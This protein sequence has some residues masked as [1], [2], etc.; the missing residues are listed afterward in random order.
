MADILQTKFPKCILLNENCHI[1][2]QISLKFVLEGQIE[3]NSA[4]VQVM[5]WFQTG[6]KPLYEPKMT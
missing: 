4:S 3:N 5:A 1:W 6:D 2:T